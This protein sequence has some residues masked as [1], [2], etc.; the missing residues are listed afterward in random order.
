MEA[1]SGGPL[2]EKSKT[3]RHLRKSLEADRNVVARAR[4]IYSAEPLKKNVQNGARWRD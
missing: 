4:N 2:N 3:L 1:A